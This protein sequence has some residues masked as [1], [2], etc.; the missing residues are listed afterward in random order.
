MQ[1]RLLKITDVAEALGLCPLTIRNNM[2]AKLR[3]LPHSPVADLPWLR[4]GRVVRLREEDLESFINSLV[5][6]V[7]GE[8]AGSLAE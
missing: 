6:E 7:V 4:I 1:N 8:A 2:S 5:P 3:G